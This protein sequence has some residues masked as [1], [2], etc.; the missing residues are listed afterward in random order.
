MKDC[1]VNGDFY[2]R[3]GRKH[4]IPALVNN[5]TIQAHA[6]NNGG[7]CVVQH[8]NATSHNIAHAQLNKAGGRYKWG[9]FKIKFVRQPPDSPDFNRNDLGLYSS[10]WSK[11]SKKVKMKM[12]TTDML[13]L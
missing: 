4:A 3:W 6:S 2:L 12:M 13:I 5:F 9:N 10:L 7:C 1:H 11:I 8:D